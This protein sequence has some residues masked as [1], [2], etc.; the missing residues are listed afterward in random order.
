MGVWGGHP[1]RVMADG[2]AWCGKA[3]GPKFRLDSEQPRGDS[4][5]AAPAGDR[6][7][8]ETGGD[9]RGELELGVCFEAKRVEGDFGVAV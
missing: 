6:D 5:A 9:A 7:R 2:E 3:C 1:Q 8:L 4:R